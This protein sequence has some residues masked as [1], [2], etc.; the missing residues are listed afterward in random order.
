MLC[1]SRVRSTCWKNALRVA[2][3]HNHLHTVAERIDLENHV[4]M[5]MWEIENETERGEMDEA[6]TTMS[7][8]LDMH[9]GVGVLTVNGGVP[10]R[11]GL[12]VD[13]KAMI[14]DQRSKTSA[15]ETTKTEPAEDMDEI[16][17]TE[18]GSNM[19]DFTDDLSRS[20][21]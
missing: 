1:K 21:A 15:E 19:N 18:A 2:T 3:R 17:F 14:W 11:D 8:E 9:G 10:E 13:A 5:E 12:I 20:A 16:E 6:N 4:G 7:D